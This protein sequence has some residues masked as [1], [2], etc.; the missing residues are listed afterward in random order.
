MARQ[1]A[2]QYVTEGTTSNFLAQINSH[3]TELYS[4]FHIV[5]SGIDIPSPALG[6]EGD[7]YIQYEN[8]T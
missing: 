3:F 6:K 4:G 2:T 7:I 1:D 5:Y 8:E